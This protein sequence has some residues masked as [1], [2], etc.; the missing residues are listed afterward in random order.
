[1]AVYTYEYDTA[2]DP[3][4]PTAEI[5]IGRDVLNDLMLTLN[6]PGHAVEI[7]S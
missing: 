3:A 7:A 4:I 1:M 6:G 5:T 2:Y